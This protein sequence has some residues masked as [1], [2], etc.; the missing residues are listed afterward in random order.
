MRKYFTNSLQE[1]IKYIAI[2]I[3]KSL[4][5]NK[6]LYFNL[7]PLEQIMIILNT[8]FLL[9]QQLTGLNINDFSQFFVELSN[10]TSNHQF[11]DFEKYS[12]LLIK[13]LRLNNDF[14]D[15]FNSIQ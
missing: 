3:M 9:L 2:Y 5:Q 4:I 15:R 7:T 8:S 12:S 1:K 10:I 13:S 14:I 6:E 11:N